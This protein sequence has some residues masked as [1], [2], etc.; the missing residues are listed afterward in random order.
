MFQHIINVYDHTK[1]LC[2]TGR[3]KNIV[4]NKSE[5]YYYDKNFYNRVIGNKPVIKVIPYDCLEIAECFVNNGYNPV[6][7]NLADQVFA[8]GQIQWGG[9]AQEESLFCRSNYFKT[10]NLQTGLYPIKGPEC[11]YSKNVYVIR[12]TD[13]SLLQKPFTVSFI[14]CAAVKEPTLEKGSLNENDYELNLKK[15]ETIFQTAS[16]KGHDTIVLSAFGCGAYKN[17]QKQIVE[18][19]NKLIEKYGHLFKFITF[20]IIPKKEMDGKYILKHNHECNYQFFLNNI[21]LN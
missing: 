21:N 1:I 7:L 6:V 14:A 5:K 2:T 13:L 16:L 12:N 19:F 15:I 17:P 20:A 11:I 9:Y 4:I 8:G 10:L 3:F 18:I